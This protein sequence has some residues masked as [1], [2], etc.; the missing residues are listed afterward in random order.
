MLS[1]RLRCIAGH[2]ISGK[3]MADIG[4]DHGYL[5]VEL[6]QSGRIPGGI[7]ADVNASPLERAREYIALSGLGECIDTRLG[8]G[9]EALS[10]G[11][12][13]TIVVAG[14]GGHLISDLLKAECS[15][16]LSAQRLI[17]QPMR[18]SEQV[19]HFL[20][21]NGFCIEVED[22]V[23]ED[24]RIYEIIVAAPGRMCFSNPLDLELGYPP[25]RR[26]D[27]LFHQ[28][29]T[30]KIHKE[31][32]ILAENSD[33]KGEFS[34]RQYTKSVQRLTALREVLNEMQ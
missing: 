4:C 12:A 3:T 25:A 24:R 13:A 11:E 32:K 10:V 5:P 7:A 31:E 6:V 20:G 33:K 2:V 21:E 1:A 27:A 34:R 18:N 23:A 17:L 9:L 26:C 16:A 15:V 14:M 30:D 19:R 28:F 22:L 29:V 8:N